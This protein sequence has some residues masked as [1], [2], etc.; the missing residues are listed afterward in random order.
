M[1]LKNTL[2]EILGLLLIIF[3]AFLAAAWAGFIVTGLLVVGVA[4]AK[5]RTDAV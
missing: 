2:F 4:L 3:G 1:N 5:E